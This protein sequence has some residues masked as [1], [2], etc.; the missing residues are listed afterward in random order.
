MSVVWSC[1]EWDQL[2]EI[3]RGPFPQQ[4]IDQT[5]LIKLLEKQGLDVIRLKLRHSKMLGGWIPLHNPGRPP[6]GNA[7]AILRL[8]SWQQLS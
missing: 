5:A 2:E 4:I 1:N 7:P 3:P 6:I 8:I